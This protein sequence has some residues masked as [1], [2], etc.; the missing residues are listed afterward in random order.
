MIGKAQ[1]LRLWSV[2]P[3]LSTIY[4]FK[5]IKRILNFVLYS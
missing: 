4:Q 3:L 1:N 5:S 2:F